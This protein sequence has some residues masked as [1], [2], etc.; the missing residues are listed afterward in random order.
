MFKKDQIHHNLMILPGTIFVFLFNTITLAGVFIAF[1]DYIPGRGWF[2]SPWVGLSNFESFFES[3]DSFEIIRNT[4]VISIGKIIFV[5]LASILFALLLNEIKSVALKRCIQTTVYLPHFISW[6]IYA[7]IIKMMLSGDG[8]VNRTLMLFGLK[9]PIIFLG[10][11][12]LFQW[13]VIGTE[14]LKE[15]GFGAIIYLAA[16]VGIN[17][18]L[19]ESAIVDGANRFKQAIYITLPCIMPTIIL[20]AT[21]SLGNILNAG[22]DQIFNLYNPAVYKTGD[23][24]DTYVYRVGLANINY[25]VGSAIGLM[26]SVISFVL[27][28]ATCAMADKFARYKIF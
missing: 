18:S 5:T 23:I 6:V 19:Y 28:T 4:L 26:K 9:E 8:M 12:G 15:F 16:I 14:I 27:I 24:I 22:F 13:I 7:T 2:S 20:L 25:G 1:Q 3:S 21:L 11:A 17:P 10:D